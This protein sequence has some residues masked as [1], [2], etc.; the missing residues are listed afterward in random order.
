LLSYLF[1]QFAV[2][3]LLA[4]MAPPLAAVWIGSRLA[5]VGYTRLAP[6]GLDARYY[7]QM[8]FRTGAAVTCLV[9]TLLNPLISSF[10]SS[11]GS[12]LLGVLLAVACLVS[13]RRGSRGG[14]HPLTEGELKKRI[15]EL[16]AK[17]GV[18]LRSVLILTSANP[19]PPAAFATRW[20][21]I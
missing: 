19:R 16:A 18:K 3:P 12:V 14:S 5:A 20:G 15:F 7:R 6:N 10:N 8:R 4:M 2:G 11:L 21:A 1:G 13:V 9:S 17:G